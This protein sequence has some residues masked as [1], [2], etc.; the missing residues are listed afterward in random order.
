[1]ISQNSVIIKFMKIVIQAG[2]IGSRLEGLTLNKPKCL[3]AVDNLPIIFH[4]FKKFSDA[5]FTIIADYKIDVLKKYLEIFAKDFKYKII[6][7]P[8]KGTISGI[9]EAI[10]SFSDNERFMIIWCDLILSDNFKIP[11]NGNYIGISCD[12]ECRWSYEN[13]K[14]IKKPSKKNGVAGLFIFENKKI[15]NNIEDEGAFVDWLSRQDINFKKVELPATKEIGTLLSYSDNISALPRHRVFNKFIF[16]DDIVI[17]SPADEQGERIA[18][19]EI[20][21]YKHVQSLNFKNIPLIY[22]FKP[23]KMKKINGK[24]IFEYK[25]LT[26]EQK[27][28][29]LKNIIDTI[30]NLHKAECEKPANI[31]DCK[32]VY[33]DKTFERLSKVEKLIPFANNELIK[34]NKQYYKNPLFYKNEIKSLIENSYPK[35]FNLIH[36][37]TTFS[38]IMFDLFDEKTVLID[39]RGYFGNTKLYGDSYYDWAKLYYS[40]NGRYDNFNRKNFYL[41]INENDV[42]F[43]IS[44]NDWEDME[45][46]FFENLPNIN[47]FKLKLLHAIIWLSLT[48]YTWEDYDSICGAFYQGVIKSNEVI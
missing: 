40:I 38:N 32:K 15:L 1:M 19:D 41:K 45:D 28:E 9:K 46:Y 6:K 31:K 18:I 17:K 29:I 5:E 27:K 34:I 33:F 44:K 22:D 8:K 11:Q 21:W 10:S 16:K 20:N 43:S 39:P 25:N 13:N 12:F 2:G 42:E 48:T 26:S 23:L 30:K 36:G 35:N 37:D 7:A 14:F 24:N 4:L 47:K 3:V